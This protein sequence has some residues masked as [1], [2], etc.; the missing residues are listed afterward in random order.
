MG[1][2]I[3]FQLTLRLGTTVKTVFD[4]LLALDEVF[5]QPRLKGRSG[6][7]ETRLAPVFLRP[8]EVAGGLIL[9]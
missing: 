4:E 2:A 7:G 6:T 3:Y 8:R 5:C 9:G 1:D